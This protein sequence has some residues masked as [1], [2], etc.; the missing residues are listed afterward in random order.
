[1]KLLRKLSFP[2]AL[3]Y[4]LVIHVRNFLF[5][6]GLLKTY[7]PKTPTICVGNV[8]VGGTG[9]TPM[10]EFLIQLLSP[11]YTV[12]ILS[13]GYGR[14]SKGYQLATANSLVEELGDEPFQIHQKFPTVALAV[15]GNR[16]EGIQYLEK[17]VSPDVILLD[18]A[19]QHRKV[20][21][22]FNIL[23]TTFDDPFPEDYFL[24]LGNLRDAKRS[25]KRADCI[26]VTKCPENITETEQQELSVLLQPKP[27]Q[28]IFFSYLKYA[29]VVKN[30]LEAISLD[31]FKQTKVVLVTGI[32]NPAPL[33]SYL[34][35]MGIYIEHLSYPD[36]HFFSEKELKTFK[37]YARIITTEKDFVRLKDHLTNVYYIGV[38]HQFLNTDEARLKA[39]LV[40]T[41]S[42]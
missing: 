19:F 23:L 31:E 11:N 25:A 20:T 1:M 14:K 8:S 41:V 21:P 37:Q 12:A 6:V 36:H 7:Q 4:G 17:Q 3:V 15:D 28:P 5:D 13:R 24:P 30:E 35:N 33:V 22:K 2:I 38:Q 16:V 9:K 42:V 32:A 27:N 18:D 34:E 10:I 29:T 40:K 26:V 39:M